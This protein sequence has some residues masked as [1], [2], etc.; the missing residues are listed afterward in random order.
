MA[1]KNKDFKFE[2]TEE[3]IH[4]AERY[5]PLSQKV[6][7]AETYAPECLRSVSITTQKLQSDSIL[8]LPQLHEENTLVKQLILM[9]GF[10]SLYLHVDTGDEFTANTYDLFAASHPMNQLERMKA[11]QNVK[12]KVFDILADYK[13]L[14]K[15]FE[16]ELYNR[17]STIND[18]VERILAAIA[19]ISD[20]ETLKKVM[21]ELKKAELPNIE[22]KAAVEEKAEA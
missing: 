8:A 16:V 19:V 7:F 4:R 10:L 20:P 17:K 15:I 13:E 1:A 21:E 22:K 5:I 3:M 12:D 6:A 14:K 9:Q 18:S 2:I 11:N